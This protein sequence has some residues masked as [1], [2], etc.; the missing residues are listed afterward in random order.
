[1]KILLPFFFGMDILVADLFTKY[2]A[3]NHLPEPI[4]IIPKYFSLEYHQNPGLAFSI[5]MPTIFQVLLSLLLLAFLI[6]YFVKRKTK[7]QPSSTLL[8]ALSRVPWGIFLSGSSL[9]T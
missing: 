7:N 4:W 9:D 3:I 2:L 5:P 8:R 1:M 6:E